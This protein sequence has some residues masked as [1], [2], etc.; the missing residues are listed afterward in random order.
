MANCGRR[1]LP[2]NQLWMVEA[3]NPESWLMVR[4]FFLE[5]LTAVRNASITGS[6][7]T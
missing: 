1:V 6:F 2:W 3:E 7:L 4:Y 5:V